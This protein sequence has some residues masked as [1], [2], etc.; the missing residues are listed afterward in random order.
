[1]RRWGDSSSPAPTSHPVQRACPG[2]G[3]LA[4]VQ[5]PPSHKQTGAPFSSLCLVWGERQREFRSPTRVHSGEADAASSTR[6]LGVPFLRKP[7]SPPGGQ[8]ADG[9]DHP[10]F[11]AR[12][13]GPGSLA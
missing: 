8:P 10:E 13:G 1:M 2:P 3:R 11:R 5:G 12:L 6:P 7:R 9:G 4:E